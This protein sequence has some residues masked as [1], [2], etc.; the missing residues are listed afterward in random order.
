VLELIQDLS[1]A[2][3]LPAAV[4][5][6]LILE[7][8][9]FEPSVQSLKQVSRVEFCYYQL[10]E[11]ERQPAAPLETLVDSYIL[12][13][14]Y[15]SPDVKTLKIFGVTDDDIRGVRRELL[16]ILKGHPRP[17]DK[18]ETAR[19][20]SEMAA[21]QIR[22]LDRPYKERRRD[23]AKTLSEEIA[24]WPAHLC[25]DGA[26]HSSAPGVKASTSL[27]DAQLETA[28]RAIAKVNNPL[29]KKIAVE[30]IESGIGTI[31]AILA[32]PHSHFASTRIVLACRRMLDGKGTLPERL[33]DLV[34]AG[35]LD[36][37]PLDPFSERPLRYSRQRA[38]LWSV[39]HDGEDDNAD[40][41]FEAQFPSGKD[42]VWKLPQ[43]KAM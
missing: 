34:D 25:T 8:P 36:R 37:L 29:G 33:P 28:R 11:L 21:Q 38:L 5:A 22:E 40:W 20:S 1:R 15:D 27:T 30:S 14:M 24:A 3:T 9:D 6:R 26:P 42:L 7:L 16:T 4:S 18:L 19:I 41:D 39:G 35:F 10:A 2:G 32:A 43:A 13:H 12:Y 17:Y 23:I 31:H